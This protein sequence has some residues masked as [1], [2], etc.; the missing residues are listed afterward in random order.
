MIEN[1]AGKLVGVK[2]KAAATVKER[3]LR[4]PRKLASIAGDPFKMGVLLYDG[5]ETMPLGDGIWAAPLST[6]WGT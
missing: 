3:D 4:G 6:L 2:V 5:A 1:A